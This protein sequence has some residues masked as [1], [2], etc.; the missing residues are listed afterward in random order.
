M[1]KR[2][3]IFPAFFFFFVMLLGSLAFT[4]ACYIGFKYQLLS[5]EHNLTLQENIRL[6]QQN[7]A[8]EERTKMLQGRIKQLEKHITILTGK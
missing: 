6:I 3:V 2:I 8:Y 7:A 1:L 5:N 4:V